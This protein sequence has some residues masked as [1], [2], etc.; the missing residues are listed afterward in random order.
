MESSGCKRT[1]FKSLC[2]RFKSI[3]GKVAFWGPIP[4]G[5]DKHQAS[6][7][8][9]QRSFS[10]INGIKRKIWQL[11]RIVEIDFW[12]GSCSDWKSLLLRLS[13]YF[14]AYIGSKGVLLKTQAP[15]T[16]LL[17]RDH[18]S[19]TDYLQSTNN[20]LKYA[21]SLFVWP[22]KVLFIIDKASGFDEWQYGNHKATQSK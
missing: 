4:V 9:E 20:L 15:A 18:V 21:L 7:Y 8:D 13:E 14:L 16:F 1:D 2:R 10:K 3:T 19:K 12:F 11:Q 5:G 17:S 22:A 6:V